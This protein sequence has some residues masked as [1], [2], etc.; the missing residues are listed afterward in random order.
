MDN[1]N[2]AT[3]GR[4]IDLLELKDTRFRLPGNV[5]L[6]VNDTWLR[7]LEKM[8][9]ATA[10]VHQPQKPISH[11]ANS[12]TNTKIQ[13]KTKIMTK[14]ELVNQL[15]EDKAMPNTNMFLADERTILHCDAQECPL[16]L[17]KDFQEL[18]PKQ[19]IHMTNGLTVLTL[20]QKAQHDMASWSSDVIDEREQLI[21][22]FL[23]IAK[24]MCSY[25]KSNGYWADFID[26]ASGRA[27]NDEYTPATF[28]ETDERYRKLGFEIEDL[29][30]CKVIAHSR[31]GTNA[32]VGALFTNAPVE[33]EAV[34][35][36]VI[37]MD[38]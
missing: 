4:E 21:G 26:P 5:G 35:S 37:Y 28:F 14:D 17:A 8:N 23:I 27:Y 13:V 15:S 1:G 7:K 11:N 6:F 12:L 32:F 31:W 20:T 29:G 33:S 25:L 30:C 9:Q 22:N 16:L 36:L 19:M 2:N 3:T 10:H 24:R 34:Q 38:D 18:F